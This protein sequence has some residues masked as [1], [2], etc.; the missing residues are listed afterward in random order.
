MIKTATDELT[1]KKVINAKTDDDRLK[2]ALF[3]DSRLQS[4]VDS[5][6]SAFISPVSGLPGVAE[7]RELR[8]PLDRRVR[9]GR[10]VRA[11]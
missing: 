11:S 8:G 6:R 9:V 10:H 5:L 2:G 7:H 4:L 3:G 1:E